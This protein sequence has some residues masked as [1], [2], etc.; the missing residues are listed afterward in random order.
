MNREFR[1]QKSEILNRNKSIQTKQLDEWLFNLNES[2]KQFITT[3]FPVTVELMKEQAQHAFDMAEDA[4]T[5]LLINQRIKDYINKRISKFADSTNEETVKTIIDSISEGII[6]GE[7]VSKLRGRIEDVYSDATSVRSERIARTE[8]IAASNE[9][10]NEAYRQSPIVTAKEWSA[11]PDACEFCAAMDGTIVG[12]EEEFAP[13]GSTVGGNEDHVYH[14][15]YEDI[16]HPPLHSNCRC[17]ILP[18]IQ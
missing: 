16:E 9:A 5:E 4:E 3:L 12:L 8:T 18:V 13:I 14:V 17:A 2:K 7:S 6:N 10:S 11:E 15:S 1:R